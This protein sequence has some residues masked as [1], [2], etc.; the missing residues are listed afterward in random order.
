VRFYRQEAIKY[1]TNILKKYHQYRKTILE[2]LIPVL[3]EN[4]DYLLCIKYCEELCKYP[5]LYI[6]G[7]DY[8]ARSLFKIRDIRSLE[9]LV[10]LEENA[11]LVSLKNY[12]ELIGDAL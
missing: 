12:K 9:K 11:K 2:S 1:Y 8:K 10:Q 3:Y 5:E 4:S 7:I 6:K